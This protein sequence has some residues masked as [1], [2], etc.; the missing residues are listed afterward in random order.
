VMMCN[1]AFHEGVSEAKAD[2]ILKQCS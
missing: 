1:D 2:E